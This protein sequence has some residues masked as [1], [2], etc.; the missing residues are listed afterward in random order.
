MVRSLGEYGEDDVKYGRRNIVAAA[1]LS[2]VAVLAM[3]MRSDAQTI[4]KFSHTDNPGGSRQAAAE[5]FA[6]KVE[7]Y[8]QGRY[9]VQVF[10]AGQLANDP[11]AVEQLQLGGID[12]TVTALG[13]SASQVRSLNL[14]SLPFLVQTYEQGWALYDKSPW[15][16]GEFA[17][18][19]A[20]GIRIIATFEAGF[21]SFTTKMPLNSPADAAGKKIRVYP[22]DMIRWI[23]ES[24]GFSPVVLPVTE[25]YL[26]IQ[27]GTVIG[28]ENPID[29]IYSL[30]F[31]EVAPY[32][33]LTQHVYSP[34]PL[35][36]SE[37][38]WKRFSDADKE[39]VTKAA[40]EAATYSRKIV[41]EAEAGQLK[42]M[43][44]KGAK[45]SRPDI[46]PWREAAKGAY[47][48]AR[49]VYGADVD[50]ILAGAEAIRKELPAK[51]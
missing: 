38:T 16:Q 41:T 25:V 8:T 46:G 50:T 14:T 48:K 42:E 4:L 7:E 9:K 32:I 20:K 19:P 5:L 13:T 12:F 35:A 23:M 37:I 49:A 33:T 21:R 39:A 18:L 26:G 6:R 31:Y 30:R 17:K 28:Q 40:Q 34:I 11:K 2:A 44:A 45:I 10:P 1:L 3:P 29:T 15:L 47:E 51:Q 27:Q 43:E 22:N 24:F 36:V